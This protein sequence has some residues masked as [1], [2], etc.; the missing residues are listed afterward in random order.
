MTSKNAIQ[1]HRR[2]RK[3]N[4]K[5]KRKSKL[6]PPIEI[7]KNI[8]APPVPTS[9]MIYSS[10]FF[11]MNSVTALLHEYYVYSSLFFI[12]TVTS[13]VVHTHD[14]L[15][16]NL[17]DKVAVS[18]IVVYGGYM[19]HS[20]LHG[21]ESMQTCDE[22]QSGLGVGIVIVFIAFLFCVYVYVYGFLTD[23]YCFCHDKCV[24]HR[25]HFLMHVMSSIG[26]HA[27]IFL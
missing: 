20:K 7:K 2:L 8:V 18:T 4:K 25:F 14:N 16:T 24:A 10:F 19:L 9:I 12:L 17:I 13:I 26:H 23:N 6:T 27:I 11:L 15:Y 3:K 1:P 21:I 5:S 22:I